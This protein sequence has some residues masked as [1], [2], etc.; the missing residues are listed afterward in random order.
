MKKVLSI[1]VG[2][3]T[4]D[5]TTEAEFLGEHFWISRQGTDGDFEKAIQMYQEYDSKVDAFGVWPGLP[6]S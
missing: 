3:A 4:R 1:S 6:F 5:H 2:S